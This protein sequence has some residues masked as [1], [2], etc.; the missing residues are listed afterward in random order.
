LLASVDFKEAKMAQKVRK[1]VIPAAGLGTRFLPVTKTLAKE[2][3]PIGT[4]PTLHMVVE[5]A[6]ASGIEEVVLVTAP[7]KTQINDYFDPDTKYM[8]EL[9]ARG[10]AEMASDL[11]ELLEKVRVRIA[12][13]EEQKGLG[14]AILCAAGDVGD[15]PFVILLPD[16]LIASVEPCSR[17]LIEAYSKTG[18]S[19]SA[20]EH[21][22][23]DKIHLYG[24]YDVDR[25]EGRIHWAKGVVE[26]PK[27][28]DAPSDLSVVG[29]YLFTHDVF[30]LLERTPPGKGGEIQLADVQNTLAREGKFLAFEYDGRQFDTGDPIGFLKANVYY[31]WKKYPEDFKAI[32]KELMGS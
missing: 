1:A 8:R 7:D 14:H 26:K 28:E 2:L 20:T 3:L 19:M 13:Q 4:K 21:T 12:Y 23:R 17:Q 30:E 24:I 6:A 25:S 18:C 22:P 11:T 31:N 5:E 27:A 32:T 29:R 10:K 9:E 15:E 16:V